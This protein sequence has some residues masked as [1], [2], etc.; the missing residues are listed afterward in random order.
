M[1]LATCPDCGGTVSTEATSCPH[2][3][4]PM[5]ETPVVVEPIRVQT[6]R[7]VQTQR[8]GGKYE[9]GGCFLIVVGMALS[10]FGYAIAPGAVWPTGV[11]FVLWALGFLIFLIGRFM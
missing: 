3:G 8:R 2:C 10:M 1:A 9:A 4:R 5:A 6:Q 7:T 11:A